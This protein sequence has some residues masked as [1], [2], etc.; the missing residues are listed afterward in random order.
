[1]PFRKL[2]LPL[3]L[4]PLLAGGCATSDV[5]GSN[6]SGSAQAQFTIC[7]GYGCE[8]ATQ[9]PITA[10]VADRFSSIM[11]S[12]SASPEAERAAISKAVKYF[13]DIAIQRIGVRDLPKSPAHGGGKNGQMD[14]IDE[15]NNTRHLLLYLRS[16]GLLKHHKVQSNVSRGFLLDGRY[17]HW[18]AVVSDP[19]G[20]K[21]AVD[22]WFEPGGGAP[23]IVP[24]DYW[25]TRG[26]MGE[27]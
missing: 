7:H 24:L 18:T 8:F 26:V 23:D 21:W 3:L 11:A 9:I 25:R 20:K 16:R 2:H 14:C 5:S 13:E 10:A 17:P 27:R 1:M 22:S 15:S 6:G 12:G 4:L 19:S